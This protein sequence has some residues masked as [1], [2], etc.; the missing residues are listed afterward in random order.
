M[1]ELKRM[2]EMKEIPAHL[3]QEALDWEKE[4]EDWGKLKE[5]EKMY[6][7]M[8]ENEKAGISFGLFPSRLICMTHEDICWL[9]ETHKIRKVIKEK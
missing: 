8:T 1:G 4:Q 9:M 5:R 3:R 2:V 6:A 7:E